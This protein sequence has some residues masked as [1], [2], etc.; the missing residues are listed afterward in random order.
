MRFILKYYV[1]DNLTLIALVT[2][3]LSFIGLV[4]YNICTYGIASV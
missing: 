1:L 3:L 2:S 4:I